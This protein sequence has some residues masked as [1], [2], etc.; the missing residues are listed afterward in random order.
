LS[1]VRKV[2]LGRKNVPLDTM[3]TADC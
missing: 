1:E 2:Q 3:A